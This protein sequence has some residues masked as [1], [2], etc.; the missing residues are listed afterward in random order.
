MNN[1]FPAVIIGGPP[2]SGKSVLAYLL[3]QQLRQQEVDHYVLR[4]CP[5]G[6][7]NWS[8]QAPPSTVQLLRYK[9]QFSAAFIDRVCRD[10]THRHLPLLVDVGGK[11]TPDQERIFD[12]CTH[13]ILIARDDAGLAAWRELA[14]RHGL[15]IV[16]ELYSTLDGQDVIDAA[17]PVLRGRVANL[18]RH[19][20]TGGPTV[21]ALSD[22]LRDL[23]MFDAA[24][25]RQRHLNH[26][27]TELAIDL[28]QLA[29]WLNLPPTQDRWEPSHLPAA[30]D[31]LPDAP[32][33]LYGRGP[34]WLYAALTLHVAPQPCHLFDVRLGWV[35]PAPLTISDTADMGILHWTLAARTDYAHLALQP[36]EPYLDYAAVAEV[37][38]P[39]LDTRQGV[40][41]SGKLPNWLLVG[42]ALA[43]RAHPWIAVFQPQL[44]HH[45]VVVFSRTAAR[46]PGS[47]I[48]LQ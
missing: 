36:A 44:Q 3:T 25:L 7:G 13:A 43:Y 35:A 4:A 39:R 9:G 21:A 5:D 26:A 30:F 19:T 15:A 34:G 38:L 42:A 41:L 48:A 29:A 47:Q 20:A 46:R 1:T 33:S 24:E 37:E 11:P 12:C 18:E 17:A 22:R 32:I 27:P 40:V 8:Q 14:Q 10:L 16:A 2:H 23:F 28:D 6:E 31:Y 45:A